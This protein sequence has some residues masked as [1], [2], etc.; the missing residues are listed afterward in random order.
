MSDRKR[1]D[2]REYRRAMNRAY[3][4]AIRRGNGADAQWFAAL[5]AGTTGARY[6]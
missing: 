3:R 2:W 5:A 4:R 6:Y 1:N